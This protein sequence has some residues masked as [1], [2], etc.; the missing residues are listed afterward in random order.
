MKRTLFLMVCISLISAGFASAD[1]ADKNAQLIQAAKDGNLPVVQTA[2]TDG[3]DVRILPY[4]VL[5]DS[6]DKRNGI[7]FTSEGKF[8]AS[9][10]SGKIFFWNIATLTNSHTLTIELPPEAPDLKQAGMLRFL[11]DGKSVAG[12]FA[13]GSKGTVYFWDITSGKLTRTIDIMP[14]NWALLAVSPSG[15]R[16]AAAQRSK[17]ELTIWDGTSGTLIQTVLLPEPPI[18]A[19]FSPDGNN[20]LIVYEQSFEIR[21]AR[22]YE[23]QRTFS[24]QDVASS[25]NKVVPVEYHG[26]TTDVHMSTTYRFHHCGDIGTDGKTVVVVCAGN[27]SGGGFFRTFV[28][29]KVI[30]TEKRVVW[31]EDAEYSYFV[32]SISISTDGTLIALPW[33]GITLR[34]VTRVEG[35]V[36]AEKQPPPSKLTLKEAHSLLTKGTLETHYGRRVSEWRLI[37]DG[38]MQ[39]YAQLLKDETGEFRIVQTLVCENPD[40]LFFALNKPRKDFDAKKLATVGGVF[41]GTLATKATIDGKTMPMLEDWTVELAADIDVRPQHPEKKTDLLPPFKEELKG[42][43]P[44]RVRNPN[45]FAVATGLRSGERGRNF[46]VPANGV[47]TVYVPDGKYDVYFV[48]SD[49]PDALFQG[50][51]FTL[52]NNGIEIQIVQIVNGNY[53]I[54][55]VK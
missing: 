44:V 48:Y 6:Y 8:I 43:N 33:N 49:K 41:N 29:I 37:P 4:R 46:D 9:C 52:N 40:G 28:V 47:E 11:N 20:L 39:A 35:N 15:E 42:S 53:N 2:L 21:S 12:Y 26:K 54:R 5:P 13:Y 14:E 18:H 31:N 51:S 22:K 30:D 38:K 27:E 1:V 45:D 36:D 24:I 23:L 55:Q 16:I 25:T 3:T 32:D 34:K 50:D 10:D 17:S 7:A 19:A